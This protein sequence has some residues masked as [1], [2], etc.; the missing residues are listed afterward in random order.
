MRPQELGPRDVDHCPHRRAAVG[1]AE[2]ATCGLL[3]ELLGDGRSA[4]GRPVCEACC[5]AGPASARGLN[6]VVASLVYARALPMRADAPQGA[7]ADRLGHLID[8]S[9]ACL[10]VVYGTPF[11]MP[12]TGPPDARPLDALIPPPA[13]RTGD[14]VREWAVGVTTAPRIRPTLEICLD[15][16][17]GAGWERPHLF[18]D[19]AVRIPERYAH[20]PYT[21][22]EEKVGAWPAYFLALAELLMRRPRADAYMI[23]QDDAL[24]FDRESLPRYLGRVLW[25]GAAPGLVSLYC[26]GPDGADRPGWHIAAGVPTS[27]PVALVFPRDLAKAFVTDRDVFEHRWDPIEAAATSIGDLI[28]FWAHDHSLPIWFPTPSLVQHI[29]DTSTLWPGARALGPHRTSRF[30]AD[31]MSEA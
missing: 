7:E 31:E 11:T 29:G 13:V 18:I 6:P 17:V 21:Y 14:P 3:D 27:G 24:V 16:L 20:L 25:P 23:V 1:A 28:P 4:V 9:R 30:V 15:G 19:A 10:D 26:N 22:R 12:P 2:A 5:R 8:R